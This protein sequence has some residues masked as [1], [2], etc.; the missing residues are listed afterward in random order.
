MEG[1]SIR[2]I[3]LFHRTEHH[4]VLENVIALQLF[5]Q[6]LLQ[7]HRLFRLPQSPPQGPQNQ[8]HQRYHLYPSVTLT[9]THQART[10]RW[11]PVQRPVKSLD[12]AICSSTAHSWTRKLYNPS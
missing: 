6:C 10:N 5:L 9:Q 11:T 7:P 3:F 8:L 1:Y 2:D 12:H 4:T